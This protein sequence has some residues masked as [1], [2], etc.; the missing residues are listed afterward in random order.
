MERVVRGVT[1][2]VEFALL[3]GKERKGKLSPSVLLLLV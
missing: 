1:R 3:K 2:Q